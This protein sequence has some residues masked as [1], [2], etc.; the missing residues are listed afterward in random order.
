[1]PIFTWSVPRRNEQVRARLRYLL[2][3]RFHEPRPVMRLV[4]QNGHAALLK[5]PLRK[6]ASPRAADLLHG[7][8]LAPFPDLHELLFQ[9]LPFVDHL[10]GRRFDR[11]LERGVERGHRRLEPPHAL[12]PPRSL[13]LEER[14]EF[15]RE[16]PREHLPDHDLAVTRQRAPFDAEA[17]ERLRDLPFEDR[18]ARAR[19]DRRRLHFE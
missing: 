15:D 16:K 3:E 9:D 17:I 14:G 18:G 11:G 1:M 6:E 12:D 4:S 2:P 5:A 8:F 7:F 19:H 13:L 10:A